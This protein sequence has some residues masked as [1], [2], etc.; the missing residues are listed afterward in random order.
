MFRRVTVISERSAGSLVSTDARCPQPE[1]SLGL[2]APRLR[3]VAAPREGRSFGSVRPS[4]FA[5]PPTRFVTTPEAAPVSRRRDRR[6]I[7]GATAC[8]TRIG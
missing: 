4:R 7:L 5:A 1:A 8:V 6:R 3:C 2:R